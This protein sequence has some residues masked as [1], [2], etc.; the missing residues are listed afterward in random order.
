MKIGWIGVHAEG[1]PALQAACEAEYDVVGLMTLR[2]EKAE[3][4]CG[5]GSYEVL[6]ERFDIP[7]SEVTHVNDESS[8]AVLKS[9]DCDVLVV[10]G[11]GQ[12]LGPDALKQ[13][14]IGVVG[15][16]A[17]FLPHNR[18]SAPVNW[19][20][21]RDESETGNSL[22]W[23]AE[24]VDS[25]NLIAQRS[26]PIT[27]YD[28]C[29]TIYDN[30]AESNREML[31]DLLRDL[32]WGDRPGIPQAGHDETILPRRRPSDGLINWNCTS[33]Q[34]YNLIRAVTR[35]YPGAFAYLNGKSYR[36]WNAALLPLTQSLAE[37]GSI[38]GPVT[39]PD[40]HGCGVLVATADGA[41]I[42]LEIEDEAGHILKG[43][44]LS[45]LTQRGWTGRKLSNAA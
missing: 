43:R 28:T 26:F 29:A 18:G 40:E 41:I 21:I 8:I 38:I 3:R 11:W 9:W 5:S 34:I 6:C 7:L 31:L 16:H 27:P 32:E 39:S 37:P 23:L 13:A 25:G 10:L 35:P 15:A 19:A 42:L 2:Q 36:V 1:L 24:G 44:Q 17:S 4:R 45:E 22:I 30:V 33:R 12:I 14:H 20:I